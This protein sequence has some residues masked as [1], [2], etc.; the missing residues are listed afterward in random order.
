[1]RRGMRRGGRGRRRRRRS[2]HG[3]DGSGGSR[4]N[5]PERRL[6]ADRGHPGLRDADR[7]RPGGSRPDAGQEHEQHHDEERDGLRD[8]IRLLLDHRRCVHVRRDQRRIHRHGR[9]LHGHLQDGR[10][11]ELDVHVL[12]DHVLR[13]GRDD[14]FRRDG[15]THAIPFVPD[16]LRDHFALH[17]PD[18]GQM[19]VGRRLAGG[20]ELP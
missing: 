16:L 8:R 15:R 2:G 3:H 6:D 4:P 14:R 20:P 9:V 5:Q 13:H 11:L 10:R 12:P 19:G 17:L 7:V 1:M 18:R